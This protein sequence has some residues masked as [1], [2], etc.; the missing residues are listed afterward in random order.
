MIEAELLGKEAPEPEGYD[1]FVH[2]AIV[3]D[4][5]GKARDGNGGD[6]VNLV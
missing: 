2:E 5:K 1:A 6:A 3:L 4:S